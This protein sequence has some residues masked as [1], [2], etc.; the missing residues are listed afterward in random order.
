MLHSKLMLLPFTLP[1]HLG[2]E[3]WER[4]NTQDVEVSIS[5]GFHL[6]LKAESSDSIEDSI[7]YAKVCEH[8]LKLTQNKSFKLIEKLTEDIRLS[9]AQAFPN[10]DRLKVKIHKL[11]PPVELLKKG[12]VYVCGDLDL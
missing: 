11:T 2:C 6:P 3:D 5:F 12:V 8:V 9:L 10:H 4:A 1:I 7:C